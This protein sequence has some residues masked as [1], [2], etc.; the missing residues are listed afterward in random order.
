[1]IKKLKRYLKNR[2]EERRVKSLILARDL[3]RLGVIEAPA[4]FKNASIN[5]LKSVCNGCGAKGSRFRPP[6]KILFTLVEPACQIHDWMWENG[7]CFEDK[8]ESDRTFHNNMNRLFA[9]DSCKWYTPT[10]LQAFIGAVYYFSVVLFGG[11]A[12]WKSKN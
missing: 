5:D 7:T 12:Y 1:M 3:A 6:S 4:S 11:P 9:R 10:M 8:Q 2:K